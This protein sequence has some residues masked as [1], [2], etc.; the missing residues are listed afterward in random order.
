[1]KSHRHTSTS[2]DLSKCDHEVLA[3]ST[4]MCVR[5][6]NDTRSVHPL[7][8][9]LAAGPAHQH[10]ASFL[11][12]GP[13]TPCPY[14]AFPCHL[15]GLFCWIAFDPSRLHRRLPGARSAFSAS[16]ERLKAS[17]PAEGGTEALPPQEL[18][19]D[20]GHS[21][22]TLHKQARARKG[23]YLLITNLHTTLF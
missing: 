21:S 11:S 5:T 9:P 6:C 12:L 15:C 16:G 10:G 14:R 3:F 8:L 1:M 22:A 20:Q 13:S 17:P 18:A 19:R 4:H 7:P 2:R 23:G